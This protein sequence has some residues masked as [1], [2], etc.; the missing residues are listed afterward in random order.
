[1]SLLKGKNVPREFWEELIQ[2]TVYLLKRL[3]TKAL[4][5]ITLYEA[6]FDKKTKP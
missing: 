3:P 4:L 2:H 6:W 5:D 1:M